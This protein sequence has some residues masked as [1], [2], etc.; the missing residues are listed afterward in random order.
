MLHRSNWTLDKTMPVGNFIFRPVFL[1]NFFHAMVLLAWMCCLPD[2]QGK[3]QAQLPM[4]DPSLDVETANR[5][6]Q[7][8]NLEMKKQNLVGAAVG[9]IDDG[10]IVYLKGYGF[11]VGFCFLF[12]HEELTPK[13]SCPSD[14]ERI[15]LDCES[16]FLLLF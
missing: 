12:P 7:G 10:K 13:K 15:L 8:V 3:L 9:V 11:E 4:P 14:K 1:G 2:S 5:I 16:M 6:D